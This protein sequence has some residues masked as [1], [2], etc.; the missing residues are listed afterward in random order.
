MSIVLHQS[1]AVK[2]AGVVSRYAFALATVVLATLLRWWLE[3]LVGPMPL[4]VTWYPAVLTV[5]V[6]AGGGPGILA[7]IAAALAADYWFIDPVGF[8][9]VQ[10]NDLVATGIFVGTGIFLSLLAERLRRARWIEAVNL[11]QEQELALL[12]MGNLMALDM[13]HRIV[14]WSEGNRRLYGFDAHEVMGRRTSDLL[15]TNFGQPLER[16]H[17]ELLEQGFW[18][19]EA[20]RRAKDGSQLSVMLHWVLR[21]DARGEPLAILEVSTDITSRKQAEVA[22]LQETDLLAFIIDRGSPN[23]FFMW[24]KEGPV[25]TDLLHRPLRRLGETP[26]TEFQGGG[27]IQGRGLR[28]RLA[29]YEDHPVRRP[30]DAGRQSPVA[31]IGL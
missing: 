8:G 20:T 18:E 21:R 1:A 5:A 19:G 14:R 31:R 16:I 13:D 23:G 12:N 17:S 27:G 24:K 26:H 29:R 6:V 15:Q 28:S 30:D 7:T 25:F 3:W 11:A 22:V 2:G 10:L 4:F 9:I